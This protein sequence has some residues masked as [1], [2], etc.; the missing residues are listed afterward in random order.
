M[1]Y[2]VIILKVE[3]VERKQNALRF[4]GLLVCWIYLTVVREVSF[5]PGG[6]LPKIEGENQLVFLRSKGDQKIFLN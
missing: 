3:K 1:L 4:H 5:L 6:G 2:K